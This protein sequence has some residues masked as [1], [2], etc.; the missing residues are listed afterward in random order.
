MRVRLINCSQ[1]QIV[2]RNLWLIWYVLVWPTPI[3]HRPGLEFRFQFRSRPG[4]IT[5]YCHL[6]PTNKL[7]LR[8]NSPCT[9]WNMS[10]QNSPAPD[11]L[12]SSTYR[13]FIG[14]YRY[15]YTLSI[16]NQSLNRMEFTHPLQFCMEPPTLSSIDSRCSFNISCSI[17]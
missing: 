11:S 2:F 16:C 10:H 3:R 15:M 9:T 6:R 12:T 13:M 8:N 4:P 17:D 7:S 14:N 1:Q 5:I